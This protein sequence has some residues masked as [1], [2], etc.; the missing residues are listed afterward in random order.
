MACAPGAPVG[1]R[2][3]AAVSASV[4]TAPACATSGLH[5]D[6]WF[7]RQDLQA[8]AVRVCRSCPLRQ[9][10]LQVAEETE[11]GWSRDRRYGVWGG[12]TPYRRWQ[13]DPWRRRGVSE[14]A[15]RQLEAIHS[16]GLQ[17]VQIAAMVGVNVT[18]VRNLRRGGRVTA[19]T[20]AKIDRLHA[21]VVGS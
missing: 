10:C 12:L 17:W 8:Q 19:E 6:A 3:V 18:V 21:R 9:R 11:A 16:T 5:P 14:R 1:C 2:G 7:D 13:R 4:E 20:A 15:R